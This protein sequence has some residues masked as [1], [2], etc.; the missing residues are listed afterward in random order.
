MFSIADVQNQTEEGF[1]AEEGAE[2]EAEEPPAEVYPIRCSLSITKVRQLLYA[3]PL[4]RV[5]NSPFSATF[6]SHLR[7]LL[8][9]CPDVGTRRCRAQARAP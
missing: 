9:I 5:L 4:A 3:L 1:E 2:A 8:P 6:I 7:R